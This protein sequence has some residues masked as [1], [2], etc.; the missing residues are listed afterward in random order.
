M[1]RFKT[2]QPNNK[3]PTKQQDG[4]SC[5]LIGF[6]IG[7]MLCVLAGA[8]TKTT[9]SLSLQVPYLTVSLREETGE[10][11]FILFRKI[12]V[13]QCSKKCPKDIETKACIVQDSVKTT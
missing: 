13:K 6:A 5:L 10:K 9:G 12:R 3:K 2:N 7:C 4:R 11:A 1:A 8:G